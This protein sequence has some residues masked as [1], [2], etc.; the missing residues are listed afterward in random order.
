MERDEQ[1]D[2]GEGGWR[3]EW[4]EVSGFCVNRLINSKSPK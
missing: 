2:G 4:G 3:E 1:V